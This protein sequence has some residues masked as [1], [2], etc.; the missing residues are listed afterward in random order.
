[1]GIVYNEDGIIPT[2]Q[3]VDKDADMFQSVTALLLR[4]ENS[5]EVIHEEENT[6]HTVP[7]NIAKT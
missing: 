3:W 4:L 5:R 7:K 6:Y 2:P 1:V